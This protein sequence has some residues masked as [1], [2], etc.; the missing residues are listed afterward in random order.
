MQGRSL[1]YYSTTLGASLP[2]DL[3]EAYAKV[4][5]I[6]VDPALNAY[7]TGFALYP[8]FPVTKGAFHT[9]SRGQSDAFISKLVIA[10][11]LGLAVSASPVTAVHGSYLTYNLTTQNYGPDWAA[12]LKLNEPLPAG[13]TFV[14]YNSG[15]GVCTVPAVGSTGAVSCTLARLDK[16]AMWNVRVVVKV[17][18]AAGSTLVNTAH[19]RSNMQDLVW[20]NNYATL[21][22]AV[23]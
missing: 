1:A 14:S 21:T 20:Q 2:T 19:I 23:N 15:G 3:S 6:A 9:V 22:T 16:G 4:L 11:D 12:Y 5:G 7:V 17:N 10:S 8:S 18:A 13:S